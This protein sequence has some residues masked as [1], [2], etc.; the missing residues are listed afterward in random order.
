[1][2]TK[3][4]GIIKEIQLRIA[5]GRLRPGGKLPSIRA[6]SKEFSCSINTVVRAYSELEK[7][8][9]VYSVPKSGYFLLENRPT[10]MTKNNDVIDFV[11]AG[12][13]RQNMP[14][15]D[16]QHCINQ[17]IEYYKEEM[18]HYSDPMGLPTLRTQLSK[19]LQNLQVFAQPDRIG[20]VSGSQQALDLLVSLP[21]PNGKTEICVE[22]PTHF[23]FIDSLTT[24][25]I[26]AIAIEIT[27]DGIDLKY[28][29]KIFRE[30]PIKFFYTVSR[31]QNPTGY[32]YS[33][34]EKKKIVDLAQ[35]YDVF[36]VEDDYMGD[37]DTRKKADPMFSFD[38]S[39]R[40]IYT[41]SFSKV[42]LPGLR[43]GLVVL[44][45]ELVSSYTKVKFAA[46]VH[47]PVLTQGALEIYLQSGMYESHIESLREKYKE[48]ARILKQAFMDY[49]PSEVTFSGAESGFYSTIILPVYLK[50]EYL[51]NNL[52][53][54]NVL[55]QNAT[56]MFLPPYRKEN[57]IRLS[58]SQIDECK[59][60]MGVKKIAEEIC[61]LLKV[62]QF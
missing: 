16:F 58:I 7:E 27:R 54:K 56:E 10:E 17:A 18:F 39:G 9:K 42:L 6:F 19:Q 43:L 22:Q 41:K 57:I 3:Y 11:T 50:A 62:S 26:N 31:F 53:K 35:K 1:M 46:D 40:I 12:P 36:I 5:D 49:L 45:T 25:E 47:T 21:F 34:K 8:H 20:V 13:D 14:Y 37:L 28:L 51:V 59:I 33:N 38:P 60:R 44:P 23:S 15:R 30:K 4:E 32:S 48:K 55:V 24:R 61:I 2:E 29:E 52:K